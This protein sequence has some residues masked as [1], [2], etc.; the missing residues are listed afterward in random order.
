MR[1]S[2]TFVNAKV[3]LYIKEEMQM[4]NK[5]KKSNLVIAIVLFMIAAVFLAYG[6]Y[7]VDYSI[8]YVQTYMEISTISPDTAFQYVVSSSAI[9]IGFAIVIFIG[10]T[11]IF[12]LRKPRNTIQEIKESEKA[13][14][15]DNAETDAHPENNPYYTAPVHAEDEEDVPEATAES[16]PAPEKISY[17]EFTPI[18]INEPISAPVKLKEETEKAQSP[19]PVADEKAELKPERESEHQQTPEPELELEPEHQREPEPEAQSEAEENIQYE[20]E[21]QQEQK[22]EPEQEQELQP[23]KEPVQKKASEPDK[24]EQ[25]PET[26]PKQ[27]SIQEQELKQKQASKTERKAKPE[28]KQELQQEQEKNSSAH[29]YESISSSMIRDIFENR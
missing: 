12:L 13:A 25:A 8:D 10:G 14:V 1:G 27:E 23:V 24:P 9:Y 19:E 2:V 28:Q 5:S 15:E 6:I 11:I 26:E 17:S 21:K 4:I 7:M 29:T 16:S 18:T 3:K 22:S 20:K